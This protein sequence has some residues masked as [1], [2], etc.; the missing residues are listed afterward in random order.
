MAKYNNFEAIK[1]ND[2][3]ILKTDKSNFTTIK[4]VFLAQGWMIEAGEGNTLYLYNEEGER[5]ELS[6]EE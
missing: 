1:T 3:L 6:W 4:Q 5:A 2:A